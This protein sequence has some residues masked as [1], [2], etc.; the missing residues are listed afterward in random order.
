MDGTLIEAWTS[1]TRF[2]KKNGSG[3]ERP[4]G[5]N[6]EV[7]FKGAACG[8]ATN[9]TC[10]D[11]DAGLYKNSQFTEAKLRLMAHALNENRHG[12]V[13]DFMATK[14]NGRAEWQAAETMLVHSVK[15]GATVGADKG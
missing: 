4:P 13:V 7:D 2:V 5:R 3:P 8:K 12:L 9:E 11:P 10:A 15:P 1:H 14:A 6:P